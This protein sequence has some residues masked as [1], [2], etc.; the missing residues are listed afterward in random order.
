MA[1]G[2]GGGEIPG[3]HTFSIKYADT[4]LS[5]CELALNVSVARLHV[6][7]EGEVTGSVLMTTEH[8]LHRGDTV[9]Y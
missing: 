1:F 8:K 3:F 6:L 2:E 4:Y 5:P 9:C 7:S